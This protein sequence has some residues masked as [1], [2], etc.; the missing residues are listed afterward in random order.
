LRACEPRLRAAL[1]R[2]VAMH[3][4]LALWHA[5]HVNFGRLLDLLDDELKLLHD[6]G[7][8]DYELMLDIMYYMTHYPDVLHHPR[9]DLVFARIKERDAAAGRTV[10]E[11]T[12]QH[13]QLRDMG[14]AMIRG[15]D[16]I[17]NG[18]ITSRERIEA[19]ARAYVDGFRAHMRTEENEMLPLAER[20]LSES[21]WTGV[22]AAIA[23][24]A[25]PLFGSQVHERYAGLRNQINRHAQA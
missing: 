17:L 25:D 16:D 14:E 21:D 10:D 1:M 13:A 22:D 8:P 4:T 2:E 15:L 23:G 18:S 12:V 7:A 20:L 11:L 6:A 19:T 3:D 5:D 24:F 9:E